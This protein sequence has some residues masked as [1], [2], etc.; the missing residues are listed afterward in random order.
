MDVKAMKNMVVLKNL[1]SNVVEEAFVVLKKNV[2][3]HKAEVLENNKK[4]KMVSKAHNEN[5]FV[6]KEAELILQEYID[7]VEVRDPIKSQK[8]VTEINKKYKRL[9]ALTIFLGL[10]SVILSILNFIK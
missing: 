4:N 6:I 5:D 3:I 7:K 1:P 10:F 2:K 8:Y 9:R